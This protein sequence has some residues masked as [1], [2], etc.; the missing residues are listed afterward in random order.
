[1][2]L[3]DCFVN[4]GFKNMF[5]DQFFKMNKSAFRA[6]KAPGTFEETGPRAHRYIPAASQSLLFARLIEGTLLWN[7]HFI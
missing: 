3:C 2:Q 4:S 7:Y 5:N 6:R 1:M